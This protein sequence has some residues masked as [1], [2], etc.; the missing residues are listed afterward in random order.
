MSSWGR[1][2]HPFALFI[3]SSTW[4]SEPLMKLLPLSML[5]SK[6]WSTW[7]PLE[8][9]LLMW[10]LTEACMMS[11]L[12]VYWSSCKENQCW[13]PE[14][15]STDLIWMMLQLNFMTSS[16][17]LGARPRSLLSFDTRHPHLGKVMSLIS[18]LW[19]S[20]LSILTGLQLMEFVLNEWDAACFQSLG[21]HVKDQR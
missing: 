6:S 12:P 8:K 13:K 3:T 9:Y 7:K 20:G 16:G 1:C 14:Y 21:R 18:S 5:F 15:R 2:W 17:H 4:V 19:E 11:Q 10:R